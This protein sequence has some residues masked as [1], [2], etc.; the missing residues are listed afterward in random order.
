MRI[1]IIGYMYSGKS[2]LGKRLAQ[3]L[4]FPFVDTD[5][6]FE[7]QNRST[8]FDFFSH[9]GESEFRQAERLIL[10]QSLA[11][12]NAVISVGGGL[13]CFFDNMNWMKSKGV[14]VYLHAEPNTII[15]RMR[16]SR[17]PRPLLANLTSEEAEQKIKNQLCE[18]SCFYE[19]AHLVYPCENANVKEL[20]TYIENYTLFNDTTLS[21]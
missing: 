4:D 10:Y 3:Y 2:S 8:V 6:V 1:F 5:T 9:Q 16:N 14:V 15:S 7:L 12:K 13:P 19:Q 11:Y 17:T 21:T 18:R 20:A